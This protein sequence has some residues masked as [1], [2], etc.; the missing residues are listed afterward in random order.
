MWPGPEG[1]RRNPPGPRSLNSPN[2]TALPAGEADA[3]EKQP[4]SGQAKQD[5]EEGAERGLECSRILL[6]SASLLPD[7]PAG[8][9]DGEVAPKPQAPDRWAVG[10]VKKDANEEIHPWSGGTKLSRRR[11]PLS[12]RYCLEPLTPEIPRWG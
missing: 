10:K 9:V 2:P 1:D 6:S 3:Q 7:S 5:D 4:E 12:T 11:H 8:K